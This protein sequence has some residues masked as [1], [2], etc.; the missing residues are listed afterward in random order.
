[1]CDCLGFLFF[2]LFGPKL[3]GQ[4]Y[5]VTHKTD[6]HGFGVIPEL[7]KID[8]SL[9]PLFP[10]RFETTTSKH[11]N[12]KK[13]FVSVLLPSGFLT[14]LSP[15]GNEEVASRGFEIKLPKLCHLYVLQV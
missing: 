11:C 3:S 14:C 2:C 6:D 1:M 7:H 10:K 9:K 4:Y 5:V 13:K 8:I 15:E 12:E